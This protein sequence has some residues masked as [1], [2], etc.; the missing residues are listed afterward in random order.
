MGAWEIVKKAISA[1]KDENKIPQKLLAQ[2]SVVALEACTLEGQG[3][4]ETQELYEALPTSVG[5][6]YNEDVKIC[7]IWTER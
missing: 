4:S 7:V 1:G 2:N 5:N 3:F 6:S